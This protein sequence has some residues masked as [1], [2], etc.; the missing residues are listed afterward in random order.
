MKQLTDNF[1]TVEIH[2]DVTTNMSCSDPLE[3]FTTDINCSETLVQQL[4]INVTTVEIHLD[5]STDINCSDPLE[6][7]T[8][9]IK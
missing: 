6:K 8:S 2:L 9:D 5:V 1:T 7:C 4:T 3:K